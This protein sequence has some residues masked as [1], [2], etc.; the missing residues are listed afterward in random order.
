MY[1]DMTLV[2]YIFQIHHQPQLIQIL[3][4]HLPPQHLQVNGNGNK[5]LVSLVQVEKYITGF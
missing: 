5:V 4:Q 3:L 1:A 2:E